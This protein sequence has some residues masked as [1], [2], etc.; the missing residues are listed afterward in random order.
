MT[1]PLKRMAWGAALL[2]VLL[3]APWGCGPSGDD[4]SEL[5]GVWINTAVLKGRPIVARF[6]GRHIRLTIGAFF[7]LDLKLTYVK[8][9]GQTFTMTVKDQD[10]H[11]A[12]YKVVKTGPD[13][14]R[15]VIEGQRYV[16]RRLPPAEAA[17]Y[18]LP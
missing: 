8:R 11:K 4:V 2:A 7:K 18:K 5:Q 12:D 10:G 1:G 17:K 14:L 16:F 6:D 9:T 3:F 13:R 15:T